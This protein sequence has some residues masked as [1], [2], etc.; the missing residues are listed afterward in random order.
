MVKLSAFLVGCPMMLSG[1]WGR[2]WRPRLAAPGEDSRVDVCPFEFIKQALL[3]YLEGSGVAVRKWTQGRRESCGRMDTILPV[4]R[5]PSE[6]TQIPLALSLR[7]VMMVSAVICP[8]TTEEEECCTN[9]R[10]GKRATL[11]PGRVSFIH[12]G[13]EFTCACRDGSTTSQNKE[14]TRGRVNRGCGRGQMCQSV[15]NPL[16]SSQQW[17]VEINNNG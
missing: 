5:K 6:S 10:D 16:G 15:H 12:I 2:K 11:L 14:K 7:M 1:F 13:P 4:V 17:S 9:A 3:A 8:T